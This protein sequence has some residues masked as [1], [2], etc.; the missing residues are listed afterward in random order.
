MHLEAVTLKHGYGEMPANMAA[1][2]Y[3]LK[4][5]LGEGGMGVVYRAFDTRTNSYV[6]L[7]TLRD[8]S[9]LATLEMFKHEWAELAKLSHPNIVDIRDVDEIE[10][11]GIRKPCFIM[12]LLPGVTLAALI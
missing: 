3:E 10:E 7:K 9:D 11:S 4:E 12:P 1:S 2:R 6:A 5:L 8:A